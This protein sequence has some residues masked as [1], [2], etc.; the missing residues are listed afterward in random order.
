MILSP[1]I[2]VPLFLILQAFR[3]V[4]IHVTVNV[5]N[6][7]QLSTVL[8]AYPLAIVF[9]RDTYDCQNTPYATLVESHI[10]TDDSSR[11]QRSILQKEYDPI[12]QMLENYLGFYCDYKGQI[13]S[14]I[15]TYRTAVPE[16]VKLWTDLM[17]TSHPRATRIF[18]CFGL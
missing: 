10:Q 7:I 15:S 18:I 5:Q 6:L 1:N 3:M 17:F 2:N 4:I 12:I 13:M 11:R 9:E 16:S 14:H 8:H